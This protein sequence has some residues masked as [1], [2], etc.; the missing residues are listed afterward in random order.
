MGSDSLLW[1]AQ[2]LTEPKQRIAFA[3]TIQR[4]VDEAAAGGPPRLPGPQVIRP[5]LIAKTAHSFWHWR[6]A[7]SDGSPQGLRGLAKVELLVSYG[8]S[9]LYH[10]PSALQP[11]LSCRGASRRGPQRRPG[12][13]QF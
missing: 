8:S 3:E 11:R 9:P 5:Y 4:M 13:A 6:S 7:R 10:G 12:A 2:R 1:R